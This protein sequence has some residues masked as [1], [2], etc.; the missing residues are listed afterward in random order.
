[1]NKKIKRL[2]ALLL[3]IGAYSTVEPTKYIGL[4]NSRVQAETTSIYLDD[5]SMSNADI[6]FD[7]DKTYYSVNVEDTVNEVKIHAA[8]KSKD[9]SVEINNYPVD[10]SDKYRAAVHLDMGENVIKIKVSNNNSMTKTYTLIVTRGKSN[11]DDV[12]LEN[13]SLSS[14]NFNFKK[15]VSS[16]DINVGSDVSKITIKA[17]PEDNNAVVNVD[18]SRVT[19]D[20]EYKETVYL[21]KGKNEIILDVESKNDKKRS[22]K[23]NINRQ[24]NSNG[25]EAQ[26]NIY[27]N[28]AK[29][30]D[31]EL[32]LSKTKTSYD[33]KVNE[34]VEKTSVHVEPE[35]EDYMVEIDGD[36]VQVSDDYTKDVS[37][38]GYKTAVNVKIEDSNNKKRVYTFNIYKGHLPA[39][40]TTSDNVN[41]GTDNN[42][43]IKKDQW[44]LVNN[45]WQYY[46]SSGQA[47][48]NT[49]FYDRSFGKNYYLQ[50]DGSMATGWLNNNGKWY[51][52]GS[53]GGMRTGWI[54][55]GN[56][57]YYLYSDGAMACST[58][59]GEYKV[60]ADGAWIN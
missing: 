28:Y 17:V 6:D 45:K 10:E 16:Y 32:K 9:S 57:Y 30:S 37:L 27:L 39:V 53:D 46:D 35:N 40:T 13:V 24:D 47:L 31:T 22:Y 23:L 2:I 15:D 21:E 5:L 55:D 33:I 59:I 18:G 41:A 19:E 20:N 7:S 52:L 51:Y 49:W 12:Y 43:N 50:A 58:K 48:K 38:N 1:M 29:V 44:V 8:P 4:M 14:G 25:A 3:I 42:S 34:D 26:D 60:G 11:A 56:K 36:A 54:F